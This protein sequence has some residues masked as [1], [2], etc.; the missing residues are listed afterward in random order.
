M[1]AALDHHKCPAF[2][3]THGQM[4]LLQLRRWQSPGLPPLHWRIYVLEPCVR[5]VDSQLL[6]RP[7]AFPERGVLA[8]PVSRADLL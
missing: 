5:E 6:D 1:P 7:M 8:W 3:N 4:S 2:H